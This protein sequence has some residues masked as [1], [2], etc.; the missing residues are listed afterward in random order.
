MPPES[1]DPASDPALE[2]LWE[3]PSLPFIFKPLSTPHNPEGIPDAL[4]F[5][6]ALDASTGRLVQRPTPE[7][8]KIVSRAYA[9]GSMIT[10]LMDE[11]GVGRPYAE[12]FLSVVGERLGGD[13]N[14]L[15]VLEI[16]SGTGYLLHRLERLGAT[17][18]G[19]EPG[20]GAD[21]AAS[22][23]G[24]AVERAFF[25]DAHVGD[26]YDVAIL[27][28]LLEHVPDP[29]GILRSMAEIMRPGGGVF[30]AVQ[31]E[32]PY[33]RQ[34]EL[35]LLF[36]EHYSYF[37]GRTLEG[38]IASAGGSS[39]RVRRSTFT[40][41]LIADYVVGSPAS[42]PVLAPED[43]A[44]AQAFRAQAEAAVAAVWELIEATRAGGGTIGLF[45]PGRAANILQIRGTSL[46]GIRFFDDAAE[47][48]GTYF[49]G[50]DI[51]VESRESLYRSPPSLLLIMSLSFG[52][53][54]RDSLLPHLPAGVQVRLLGDL[55]DARKAG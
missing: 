48:E 15:R 29:A 34:G 3:L 10:G 5:H 11:T 28:L 54:I 41:L 21:E 7:L 27:H 18:Q 42:E 51:P 20:P 19:V 31:D 55:L 26:G 53:K 8:E 17:V 2:I 25:P 13:M 45:V 50:I 38:L 40:N 49:P 4:P 9:D 23:Y 14:D 1:A 43:V 16:G 36:H 37:T 24:V 39:I 33:I 35:S 22:R 44:L 52:A 30:V 32:E 6:L 12:D 46:A 47:L